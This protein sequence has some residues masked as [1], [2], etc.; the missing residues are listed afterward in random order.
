MHVDA[1]PPTR[2]LFRI[3]ASEIMTE[4]SAV[5]EDQGL[6][7]RSGE[8]KESKLGLSGV[9]IYFE[10]KPGRENKARALLKILQKSMRRGKMESRL[11]R[12]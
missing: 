5:L 6:I 10:V 7:L 12:D 8:L 9:E 3:S 4:L 2:K 11:K 1:P